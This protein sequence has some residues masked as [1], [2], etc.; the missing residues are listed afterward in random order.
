M[1]SLWLIANTTFIVD[2]NSNIKPVWPFY[3]SCT[4]ADVAHL[5]LRQDWQQH[6]KETRQDIGVKYVRFHGIFDDDVGI[7]NG[8]NDYSYVNVDKIYDYV[9]SLGM[10][11]LVELDFMPQLF[12]L[13]QTPDPSYHSPVYG[14]PPSNYTIWTEFITDFINHLIDRYGIDE[15][16]TWSFEAWNVCM[17]MYT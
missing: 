7:V 8:Y 6:L 10:K 4:T 2:F 3:E 16:L 11:P 1:H 15:I 14:S 5:A 17:T 12:A 9:L 13:I